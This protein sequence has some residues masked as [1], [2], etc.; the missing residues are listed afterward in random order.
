[1]KVCPF[2]FAYFQLFLTR[3]AFFKPPAHPV[4]VE[5]PETSNEPSREDLKNA[6]SLMVPAIPATWIR[7]GHGCG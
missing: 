7:H 3:L 5:P 6:P 4:D 2:R 1:L